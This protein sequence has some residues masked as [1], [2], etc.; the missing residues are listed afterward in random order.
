MAQWD[1]ISQLKDDPYAVSLDNSQIYCN[2]GVKALI[3]LFYG[4]TEDLS[5]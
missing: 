4:H 5:F 1:S 2:N 3:V